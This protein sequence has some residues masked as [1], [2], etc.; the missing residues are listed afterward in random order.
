MKLYVGVN[1][2]NK[3]D[4]RNIECN[5]NDEEN[6]IKIIKDVIHDEMNATGFVFTVDLEK[7]KDI[8][9]VTAI[10][11][12]IQKLVEQLDGK[13]NTHVVDELEVKVD[14]LRDV[15]GEEK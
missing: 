10:A 6:L 9:S 5:P 13:D 1:Y 8:P 2:P 12:D 7:D 14:L 3:G 11:K 4:E 15:V